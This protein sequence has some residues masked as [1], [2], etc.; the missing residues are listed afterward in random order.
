MN[1]DEVE[2]LLLLAKRIATSGNKAGARAIIRSLTHQYPDD[3]RAWLLLAK[4]AE[5]PVE[6][7]QALHHVLRLRPR[8]ELIQW[9]IR[10]TDPTTGEPKPPATFWTTYRLPALFILASV[11]FMTSLLTI[12]LL[13]GQNPFSALFFSTGYATQTAHQNDHAPTQ[14]PTP[15]PTPTP[16]PRPYPTIL[17]L[18]TLLEHNGWYITLFR[19]EY[20]QV[21]QQPIG[22]ATPEGNFILALPAIG[23]TYPQAR[24]IPPGLIILTDAEGRS[25]MPDRNASNAYLTVYRRGT[26]G[27]LSLQDAIPPGGGLNTVPLIFD[28]PTD[29]TALLLT[30][31]GSNNAGWILPN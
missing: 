21:L 13:L 12:T 20:L 15:S 24:R 31:I 28:V 9:L 4:Y 19:N 11:I 22:D 10:N 17:R 26:H 7:Y 14:A 5:T 30:T 6:R 29:A 18:G 3:A 25:Y 1:N 23:N 27:D 16:Q 8:L 2:A